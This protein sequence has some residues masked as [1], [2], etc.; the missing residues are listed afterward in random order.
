MFNIALSVHQLDNDIKS[1][2][3]K[4]DMS[5][6]ASYGWWMSQAP[7]GLKF[8]PI[9]TGELTNDGKKKCHNTLEIDQMNDI[10]RNIQFLLNR[11]SEGD[12]AP[13][14][15]VDLAHKIG[16]SGKNGKPIR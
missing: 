2:T 9:V 11:F 10:G 15:L 1:K 13:M 14:E 4:D 8:K 3:V 5:L 16:V 6:L 12:I 7:I